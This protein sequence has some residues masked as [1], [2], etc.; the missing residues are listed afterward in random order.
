MTPGQYRSSFDKARS[1]F[2][3]VSL[4]KDM[5]LTY[6]PSR[7]TI[8]DPGL[9]DYVEAYRTAIEQLKYDILLFDDSIMQFAYERAVGGKA[10]IR[11]TYYQF[12]F[13][14]PTYEEYLARNGLTY[15][16][17]GEL[18]RDYYEQELSEAALI[19]YPTSIRYDYNED[20]YTHGV[21]AASHI[22]IGYRSPL[23]IA[24]CMV[25]T[26]YLFSLFVAKQCYY[27]RWCELIRDAQFRR[28]LVASKT[29]CT[30]LPN[31]LFADLDKKELYLK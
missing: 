19:R 24:V 7:G 8:N 30:E 2:R 17:A 22:H 5:A 23:R 4:S 28:K 29:S 1:L 6:V 12:P 27:D 18:F 15:C 11:Y 13:D 26:P 25:L 3:A 20:L 31:C 21:H 14:F 9:G 10:Y 16:E